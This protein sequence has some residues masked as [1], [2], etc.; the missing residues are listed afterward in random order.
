MKLILENFRKFVNEGEDKVSKKISY[1]MDKE[2]EKH[3]RAVAIAL[4]MKDRGELE[5]GFK[6]GEKITHDE[7]GD[8]LLYTSPSP[9]DYAASRMPSSA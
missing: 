6:S 8:C 4:S 9:R 5:E 2:G 3:D 1:L 7:Y